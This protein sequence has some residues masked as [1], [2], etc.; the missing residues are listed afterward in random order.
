MFRIHK[1]GAAK[2]PTNYPSFAVPLEEAKI[3]Y[4][5]MS[6]RIAS[7]VEVSIEKRVR[8]LSK[9]ISPLNKQDQKIMSLKM[10]YG[11]IPET[12]E[13]GWKSYGEIRKEYEINKAET[14]FLDE[15]PKPLPP[16]EDNK[17]REEDFIDKPQELKIIEMEPEEEDWGFGDDFESDW[18]NP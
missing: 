9:K 17:C 12:K 14:F 3:A 5:T 6:G 1:R 16:I 11:S 7:D 2:P 18:K 4:R 10:A 13:S 15:A 8:P